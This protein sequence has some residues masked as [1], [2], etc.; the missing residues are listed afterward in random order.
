MPL[1]SAS[2]S[3]RMVRPLL[4]EGSNRNRKIETHSGAV[5]GK[6]VQTT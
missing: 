2:I 3:A 5:K 6:L 4:G 1:V